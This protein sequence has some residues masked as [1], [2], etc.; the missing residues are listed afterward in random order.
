MFNILI[1][2]HYFLL[3]AQKKN[4]VFVNNTTFIFTILNLPTLVEKVQDS[5]NL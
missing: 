5:C 1:S 2:I 3:I 4:Y